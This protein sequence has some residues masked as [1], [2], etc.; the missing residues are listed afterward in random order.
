VPSPTGRRPSAD[1]TVELAERTLPPPVRPFF[2]LDDILFLAQLPVI[3]L[4]AQT[5]PERHWHRLAAYIAEAR[6][7]VLRK[8]SCDRVRRIFTAFD[9]KKS[10]SECSR[11]ARMA[12]AGRIE[13]H[14]Q[15]LKVVGLGGWHPAIELS[16]EQHLRNSLESGCG[17][18]LWVA[19]FC[20][21]TQITKM[22]LSQAGYR[23]AHVSRPEHGF[24]KSRFGI[25]VLNPLRWKAETPYLEQRI[26][27]D[28]NAP[29]RAM[30][31]A[32]AILARNGIVSITM[33]AWEGRRIARFPLLGG[34]L[35]LATGAAALAQSTGATLLPVFAVRM[36]DS[37]GFRVRVGEPLPAA[38]LAGP[39]EAARHACAALAGRLEAAVRDDPAQWRGW[40]ELGS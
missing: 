11:I 25:R 29:R 34:R 16:G 13:H 1:G 37:Q 5:L 27:I 17:A 19:H 40:G 30:A 8:S 39:A 33:G 26:V 2:S 10:R 4:G 31:D 3:W 24:S 35:T 32:A 9:G 22:A 12:D 15:V 21:N 38:G 14:M 28:R 20:F 6:S 7:V 23:V 36:A 18:I